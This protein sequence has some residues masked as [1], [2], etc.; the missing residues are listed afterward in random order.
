MYLS[1]FLKAFEGVRGTTCRRFSCKLS[2]GISSFFLLSGT[3]RIGPVGFTIEPSLVRDTGKTLLIDREAEAEKQLKQ[4]HFLSEYLKCETTSDCCFNS[5]CA[6]P[7]KAVR[8]TSDHKTCVMNSKKGDI[9]AYCTPCRPVAAHYVNGVCD[10]STAP[11]PPA[12]PATRPVPITATNTAGGAFDSGTDVD[13]DAR[14]PRVRR[15]R[16][17]EANVAGDLP[18]YDVSSAVVDQIARVVIQQGL[19]HK[20]QGIEEWCVEETKSENKKKASHEGL[21]SVLSKQELEDI[22]QLEKFVA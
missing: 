1:G 2:L 10:P 7:S 3:G 13:D 4:P 17:P 9:E 21:E 8:D 6:W 19:Q 15:K 20:C 5:T 11:K 12:S 14:S 18:H 22:K 16:I